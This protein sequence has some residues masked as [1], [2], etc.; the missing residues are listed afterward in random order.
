M[1]A[2]DQLQ[3]ARAEADVDRVSDAELPEHKR[4]SV[5]LFDPYDSRRFANEDEARA[6]WIET[7][8]VRSPI[9]RD[10]LTNEVVEPRDA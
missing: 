10:L 4:Y 9:I 1:R 7:S 3:C 2:D 6:F 8:P 5:E